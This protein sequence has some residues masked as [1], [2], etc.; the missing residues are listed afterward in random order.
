MLT[1][2]GVSCLVFKE[3]LLF[4]SLPLSRPEFYLIMSK[5]L[6]Q[7]PFYGKRSSR[8]ADPVRFCCKYVGRRF[9]PELH[10]I[11]P[12][13]LIQATVY[14]KLPGLLTFCQF[15]PLQRHESYISRFRETC[16]HIKRHDIYNR[17]C[18]VAFNTPCSILLNSSRRKGLE[19][20]AL[21]PY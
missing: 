9:R 19:I 20:T 6:F 11:M 13:M 2:H 10:L 21:K 8:L 12:G 15:P 16:Q 18:V 5:A 17:S 14:G 3:H 4:S 7:A 1:S